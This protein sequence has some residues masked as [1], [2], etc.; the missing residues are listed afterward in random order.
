MLDLLLSSRLAYW[1]EAGVHIIIE[2][3]AIMRHYAQTTL[4]V[5]MLSTLHVVPSLALQASAPWVRLPALLKLSQLPSLV[6]TFGDHIHTGGEPTPYAL[7]K[8]RKLAFCG[9]L[10]VHWTACL[11]RVTHGYPE[12]TPTA[13]TPTAAT[14][15]VT[16]NTT[17]EVTSTLNVTSTHP[18]S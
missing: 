10:L 8:L 12:P 1:Q 9:F 14:L 17:L 5:N 7:R 6:E 13:A 15:N 11:Y 3:H 4:A 18:L 2:P 16:L